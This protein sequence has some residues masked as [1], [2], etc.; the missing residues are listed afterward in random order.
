MEIDEEDAGKSTPG[1]DRC[2]PFLYMQE[3]SDIG[4]W[5]QRAISTCDRIVRS[6]IQLVAASVTAKESIVS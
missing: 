6:Q 1:E 5:S 3:E 4:Q 2:A